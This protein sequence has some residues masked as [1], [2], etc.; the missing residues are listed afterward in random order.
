MRIDVW[1]DF[2]GPETLHTLDELTE[3][4]TA[5]GH[6]GE[7][8]LVWHSFEQDRS[9]G[10]RNTFDAH[11]VHHLARTHGLGDAAVEALARA[12]ADGT[13]LGDR[14]ALV[15]I[16]TA[17]GLAEDEV[18]EMLDGDGSGYPVRV[19]EATAKMAGIETAPTIVFGQ[20]YSLAGVQPFETILMAL[21]QAWAE[22]DI[23]PTAR[24]GMCGDGG[25][26]CGDSG[27]GAS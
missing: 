3:A 18:R 17:V 2:C 20:K 16:A 11:R 22:K 10:E 19:D 1:A 24:G 14:A 21:E 6:E 9:P 8:E 12:A 23:A 25:C 4:M 26:G 27:C 7:L 5:S 13:A 15:P